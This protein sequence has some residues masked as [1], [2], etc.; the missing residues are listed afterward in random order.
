MIITQAKGEKMKVKVVCSDPHSPQGIFEFDEKLASKL[1]QRPHYKYAEEDLI[2]PV[3]KKKEI[4][5]KE[6]EEN[7]C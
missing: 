1:V 5:I 6:S 2:K 4:M 3:K 7:V